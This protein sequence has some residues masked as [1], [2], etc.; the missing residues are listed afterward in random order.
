MT[1]LNYSYRQYIIHN[2]NILQQNNTKRAANCCLC[3]K[4]SY[5]ILNNV[6]TRYNNNIYITEPSDLQQTY[7]NQFNK[8]VL[9]SQFHTHYI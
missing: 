5:D 9:K 6:Y 2:A 3:Y 1:D 4:C 8:H 7:N